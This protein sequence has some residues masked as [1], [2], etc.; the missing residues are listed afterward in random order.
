MKESE[1][2]KLI[3]RYGKPFA[4]AC[5]EELDNYKGAKK[6]RTYKDDYRAILSWVVDRINEKRPGFMSASKAATSEPRKT[7]NPFEEWGD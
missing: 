3:Q 5:I 2:E 7:G 1:Y 6:G 4:D